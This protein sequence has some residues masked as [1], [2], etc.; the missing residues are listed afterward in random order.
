M[1]VATCCFILFGCTLFLCLGD[2]VQSCLDWAPSSQVLQHTPAVPMAVSW[3][4]TGS[5][6]Y[7]LHLV[8]LYW[9]VV[10]SQQI[11]V[12]WNWQI[13]LQVVKVITSHRL[14]LCSPALLP[15]KSWS[16]KV[17]CCLLYLSSSLLLL[18]QVGDFRIYQ[19]CLIVHFI[20]TQSGT[21]IQ[22]FIPTVGELALQRSQP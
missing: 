7:W 6:D 14:V 3:S 19:V 9:L 10:S 11:D 17:N 5:L 16:V 15:F 12:Y 22:L 13:V 4:R 21:G 8:S 18:L 1:T 2:W 20:S